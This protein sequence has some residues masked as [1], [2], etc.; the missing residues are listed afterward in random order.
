MDF[1]DVLAFVTVAKLKSF[2][3]A[4]E[5]LHIAQSALSRRVHRLEQHLGVTLLERHARGVRVTK[6]GALL[7]DKAG[8]LEAEL[9][10]I[11]QDIRATARN[12]PEEIR[13]AMPPGAARLFASP[14]VA[15][16][17]VSCPNVR[18]QLFEKQSA[19]NRESALRG[20]VDLALV[21]D[22]E[23]SN[24]LSFT[25]LLFER[26]L[27]IARAS[28]EMD[29]A[30]GPAGY[31]VN[32]LARLPLILP[33]LPHAYRRIVENITA[34]HGLTPNIALEVNGFA[35][36]LM[37]VQQGLGFAI[38]T[39]PPVE[40]EIEAGRLVGIPI[41]S[42]SCEVQLSIVHR[43]DR[44]LGQPQEALKSVFVEVSRN[45]EPSPYW[46]PASG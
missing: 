3:A 40:A 34:S 26:I 37:M 41:T 1:R 16:F 10:R 36:S 19:L 31:E 39:Y 38:S 12:Q 17:Q 22:A 4:A 18:L 23:P 32:D 2:S 15:R 45:I 21:Y 30:P 33:G 13:V 11:E 42:P 14:V 20:E 8:Q 5:K 46:R 29:I 24:E 44:S 27:V 28:G 25:P 43:R 35:T 9:H 7:L 6:L